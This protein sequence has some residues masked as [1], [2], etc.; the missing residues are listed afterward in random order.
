[1]NIEHAFACARMCGCLWVGIHACACSSLPGI[2]LAQTVA[3]G[4]T[5]LIVLLWIMQRPSSKCCSSELWLN[6]RSDRAKPVSPAKTGS[7]C[8]SLPLRPTAA[9]QESISA[10]ANQ[11]VKEM[12][13]IL[14]CCSFGGGS[15]AL[16]GCM[17]DLQTR[18]RYSPLLGGSL[19]LFPPRVRDRSKMA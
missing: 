3:T 17:F 6:V 7:L 18:V 11:G 19:G 8:L 15:A 13:S 2:G 16:F 5:P 1:M 14:P 9:A 10:S 4:Q 12:L